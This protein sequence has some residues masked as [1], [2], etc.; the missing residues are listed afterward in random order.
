MASAGLE[1]T[2]VTAVNYELT[3]KLLPEYLYYDLHD[4]RQQTFTFTKLL[5]ML[6]PLTCH[7]SIQ[8]IFSEAN[9]ENFDFFFNIFAQNIHCG[10]MLE[11]SEVVLMNTHNACWGSKIRKIGISLQTTVLLYK[12]GV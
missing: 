5:L 7:G 1:P 4:I 9:I 10:Y 11:P 6:L 2:P 12:S 3:I 8:R